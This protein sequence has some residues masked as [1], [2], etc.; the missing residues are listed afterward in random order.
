MI[1]H[2]HESAN[3][4][5][6]HNKPARHRLIWI[7]AD[8]C[9]FAGLAGPPSTRNMGTILLYVS[10]RRPIS[11]SIDGGAWET[12]H[13]AVV[14]AYVPHRVASDDKLVVILHVEPETVD[15]ASLP[16]YLKG[17]SGCVHDPALVQRVRAAYEQLA[18]SDGV[19]DPR[20]ADFDTL[21]WGKQL[22][23][24]VLERRIA[25][26]VGW[27]KHDPCGHISAADCA[28]S[29]GLSVSRFLHLFKEKTGVPFR[30]YRTWKRARSLLYHVTRSTNLAYLA[31]DVGYPDST[32]LSHVVRQVYG[33]TP[34][35]L[36]KGCL[37]MRMYG[38]S[39]P[40]PCAI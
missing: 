36:F 6:L 12:T 4:S 35:A 1:R 15:F 9:F 22:A 2:F 23:P 19:V 37:A 24:R 39:V 18:S 38:H 25:Q 10:L 14:Q 17:D 8:R 27:I 34:T 26:V 31:L 28:T 33:M 32:H 13:V 30:S 16:S 29:T 20:T 40:A 7:N 11:V 5:A 21:F 3:P